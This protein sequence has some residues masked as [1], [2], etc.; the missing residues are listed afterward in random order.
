V[1]VPEV[2]PREG[3]YTLFVL[4]IEDVYDG[5]GDP[6]EL[7]VAT[8]A[9]V[10]SSDSVP[11]NTAFHEYVIDP[12]VYRRQAF[13]GGRSLG[14]VSPSWGS[15]ELNN[16]PVQGSAQG[17]DAWVNY[18]TDGAKVTCWYGPYGGVFPDE[19]RPSYIAYVDG[20]PT[21][22]SKSIRMNLRGRERLFDQPVVTLGFDGSGDEQ[23]TGV[24]GAAKR[25]LVMGDP[26]YVSPILIHE[27][28]NIWFIAG[29][30][31]VDSPDVSGAF[32]GGV[33]LNYG[34]EYASL[35]SLFVDS[36][37]SPGEYKLF[38]ETN[39]DTY[40]RLGSFI[41]VE[42]RVKYT[43]MY[44]SPF[45][46]RRRWNILDLAQRAGIADASASTMPTG[47]V[48]LDAGNRVVASETY[49]AVLSDVGL[50]NLALIGFD[51]LDRFY[52]KYV[53]PASGD[54]VATFYEGENSRSWSVYSASGFE[55]RI[56][57]VEVRAGATTRGALAG[58]VEDADVLDGLSRGPWISSFVLTPRYYT[59]MF[60]PPKSVVE[61]DPGAEQVELE[62]VDNVFGFDRAKMEAWGLK[63]CQLYSS[64]SV[65]VSFEAPFTRENMAIELLDKV[66][67]STPRYMGSVV[68]LV[69]SID[70]QLKSRLIKF[71][72][73]CHLAQVPNS[74]EIYLDYADDVV[75]SGGGGRGSGAAGTGSDAPPIESFVIA[76][77][78][79]TTA[80]AA[81]VSKRSF[82][83]PYNF[84]ITELIASL[85]TPQTSGTT[86]TVD[87]NHNGASILST[88]LT[89]DN[90]SES[91][92]NAVSQYV[93]SQSQLSKSVK[94]TVDIDQIGD[95][96]AKGLVVTLI[97]YR[98]G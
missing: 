47:S 30:P 17:F 55:S 80:L 44:E 9:I 56:W 75:G 1:G 8:K 31:I 20:R 10:T 93:L 62:I 54:T 11:A 42:L 97:G 43:G 68:G 81:G 6:V 3:G 46:V 82:F 53:V 89:I 79:E 96:T 70:A 91:S 61:Y 7:W 49:K 66:T 5:A 90:T 4:H 34:G 25:Q 69:V 60:S 78:D 94:M 26:G 73:W 72:V 74:T 41:R 36:A 84:Q 38:H 14:F 32:D 76:V 33:E 63:F 57:R 58:V 50:S 27:V 48:V 23:G 92:L 40:I 67:L 87:L 64:R 59:G 98:L 15:I 35:T 65:F 24:A 19:Y 71:V 88:K 18:S 12:G 28:D 95:G 51:R 16:H 77:S 39:G 83:V 37:P 21:V 13:A 86:F 85:T 45:V 52:A 2:T 22:T 29:N